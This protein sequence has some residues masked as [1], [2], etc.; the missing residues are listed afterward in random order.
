LKEQSQLLEKL[1]ILKRGEKTP[2]KRQ[3]SI[4]VVQT[5]NANKEKTYTE[6]KE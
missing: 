3:A 6:K 5:E 4:K 2:A 1:G